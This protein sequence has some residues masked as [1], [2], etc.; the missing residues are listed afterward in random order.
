MASFAA[1][2]PELRRARKRPVLFRVR[3]RRAERL[4][5]QPRLVCRGFRSRL[6]PVNTL[7]RVLAIGALGA[8]GALLRYALSDAVGRVVQGPAWLSTLVVNVLGCYLLGVVDRLALAGTVSPGL[9]LLIAV[10]FVGSFTTFSTYVREMVALGSEREFASLLFQVLAQ[11]LLGVLAVLA[12]MATV[13]A[14]RP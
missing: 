13:A 3:P 5:V 12:G 14:F 10:G 9:R 7:E 1:S 4:A 11:N 2:K 6:S 8:A